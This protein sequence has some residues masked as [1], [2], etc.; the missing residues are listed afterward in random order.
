MAMLTRSSGVIVIDK[1]RGMTS[2]A[3]V[4]RVKRILGARKAG[5]TGTLDPM[6]TGVLPI[7]VNEAT[8]VAG[9]IRDAEKVYAGE[10]LL[11][12]E[13]TTLDI[14]GDRLVE[15]D[16]RNVTRSALLS[17]MTTF[18]GEVQQVPP[19]FSAVHVGGQRAYK[20][21]RRGETPKLAARTVRIDRFDLCRWEPPRF[22]FEVA[23][24]KGTYI[25]SLVRDVGEALG[26]GATLN[27]LR[28][29]QSGCFRIEQAMTLEELCSQAESGKVA[30]IPIE[31]AVPELPTVELSPE[32]AGRLGRGQP[33]PFTQKISPFRDADRNP[34]SVHPID[35]Q[36]PIRVSCQGKTVALALQRGSQLWPKRV[37]CGWEG[38][39]SGG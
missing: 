11:G 4:L 39:S 17:A 2:S 14:T 1:P 13:T 36:G 34:S 29:L 20:L 28:R 25:R 22:S 23:S 32:D 15:R 9:Y 18:V 30:F 31:D 3:V 24:G 19:S 6:A 26:C 7:C 21:A 35:D 16:A 12:I 38:C 37:F 8:K 33:V 27:S 5:H 10:G